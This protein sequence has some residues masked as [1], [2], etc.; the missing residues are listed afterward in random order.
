MLSWCVGIPAAI[1]VSIAGF[2]LFEIIVRDRGPRRPWN[3]T[4]IDSSDFHPFLR[5]SCPD[6]HLKWGTN[7]VVLI[8]LC[9]AVQHQ[10]IPQAI[11]GMDVLC[12]AKSGMGKTAVFVLSVLQQLEP[13]ENQVAAVIVCHTREL[14]Y[15]VIAL[16]DRNC[17]FSWHIL[18]VRLRPVWK[19][20]NA[21]WL[22][23]S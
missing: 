17:I 14:A 11:L 23:A 22:A 18:T 13:Q 10:C 7:E 12:Q 5:W 20:P 8:F 19:K 4:I 2:G 21:Y 15:Q 6:L 3:A 9:C 16:L 1:S